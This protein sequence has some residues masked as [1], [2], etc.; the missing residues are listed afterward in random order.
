ET[1]GCGWIRQFDPDHPAAVRVRVHL[2]R[3]VFEAA[4]DFDDFPGGWRIQ[5]RYGL[6][7]LDCAERLPRLELR[8]H[9]RQIDV[10]HVAQLLLSI[11][12]DADCSAVTRN[13]DPLVIFCVLVTGRVA[14]RVSINATPWRARPTARS[15]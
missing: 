13:L 1:A 7:R 3:L 8:P 10:H 2:L 15:L 5:L 12:G 14:H 6:D 9:V 11:L 4:I